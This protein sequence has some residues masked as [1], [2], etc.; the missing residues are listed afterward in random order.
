MS[1]DYFS[2]KLIFK[3]LSDIYSIHSC[4]PLKM[5]TLYLDM[6]SLEYAA[7][8]YLKRNFESQASTTIKRL[9]CGFPRTFSY[10][11][12]KKFVEKY[13]FGTRNNF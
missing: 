7:L 1:K 6:T 13:F 4:M 2:L 5:N 8:W 12:F 3:K 10:K 9:Q 11:F